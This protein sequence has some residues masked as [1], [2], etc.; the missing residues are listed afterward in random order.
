MR[1]DTHTHTQRERERERERELRLRRE[2]DERGVGGEVE[3]RTVTRS[4]VG[5][6][7]RGRREHV[8]V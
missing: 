5:D 7:R 1:F 8:T 4:R 3:R 2:R 6:N